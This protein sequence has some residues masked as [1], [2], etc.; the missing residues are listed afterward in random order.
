MVIAVAHSLEGIGRVMVMDE[1]RVVEVNDARKLLE[2]E[3]VTV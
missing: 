2:K 3:G 1:G